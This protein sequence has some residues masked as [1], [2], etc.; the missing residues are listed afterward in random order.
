M[1]CVRSGKWDITEDGSDVFSGA[2]N[3]A[4]DM[5]CAWGGLVSQGIREGRHQHMD[6]PELE[7]L[8]GLPECRGA[9][10]GAGKDA[11]WVETGSSLRMEAIDLEALSLMPET[12]IAPGE[13]SDQS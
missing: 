5:R 11:V 9:C 1:R 12:S 4:R 6:L 3:D 2:C 13:W 10:R 7:A 8:N